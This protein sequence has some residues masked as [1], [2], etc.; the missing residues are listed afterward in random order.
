MKYKISFIKFFYILFFIFTI[1]NSFHYE[2]FAHDITPKHILIIN[3]Y[4]KCVKR[5]EYMMDKLIPILKS[6]N[7]CLDITVEYMDTKSFN[8]SEYMKN[9]YKFYKK[10][11]MEKKFDLI[12]SIDDDSLN[13]L[14]KYSKSLFP[15]TPI[16]FTGGNYID[17][18]LLK[19]NPLFTGMIE[20]PPLKETI[21]LALTLNKNTKNIIV[22]NDNSLKGLSLKKSLDAIIPNFK[23]KVNF[24]FLD[25]IN[26]LH[27]KD[28]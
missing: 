17:E 10:K 19:G 2:V 5:S 24:I 14:T 20:R 3:S 11:F 26:L 22:I 21:D 28:F 8:N 13:F 23:R 6:S 4:D 15:N 25:N 1:F 16:V 18:S 12:I 7:E 27:N 9:I